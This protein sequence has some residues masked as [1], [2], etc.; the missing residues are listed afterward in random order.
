MSFQ[1]VPGL[2]T[3]AFEINKKHNFKSLLLKHTFPPD[4]INDMYLLKKHCYQSLSFLW[5]LG[6][7]S[8]CLSDFPFWDLFI[9][10]LKIFYFD[11][12]HF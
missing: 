6:L 1:G 4:S 11:V 8:L 9:Y 12:Y 2:K 7:E 10:L 5:S 3:I